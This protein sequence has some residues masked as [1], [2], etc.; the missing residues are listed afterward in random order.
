M[1]FFGSVLV[2]IAFLWL[3][4]AATLSFKRKKFFGLTILALIVGL[5]TGFE[6]AWKWYAPT[7]LRTITGRI[8]AIESDQALAA[9][10]SY[11]ALTKLES[12]KESEAKEQLGKQVASYYCK[13]KNAPQLSDY[14]KKMVSTIEEGAAKSETLKK[15]LQAE[16]R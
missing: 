5:I 14:G 6:V 7:L 11:S 2:A 16:P 15:E 3:V 9:V 12:G 13:L 10:I 4:V 8:Q 1:F